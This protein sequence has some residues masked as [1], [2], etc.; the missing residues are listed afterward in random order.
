[1]GK[2]PRILQSGKTSPDVYAAMWEAL[3]QALPWKGELCN[4]R[5]DG[6]EYFQFVHISPIRQPDGRVTHYV[7]FNEDITE[8]R[9]LGEEL[10]LHRNRLEQLV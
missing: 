7:A 1:M 10:D 4:R 9:R 8:K 5:K 3:T 2:N 6:T